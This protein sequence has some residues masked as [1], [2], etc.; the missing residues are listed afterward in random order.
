MAFLNFFEQILESIDDSMT[1]RVVPFVN[2]TEVYNEGWLIRLLVYQS[3]KYNVVIDGLIDFSE[4]NSW[5]S[6]GLISSPFIKVDVKREGYTHAD[7]ALGDFSINYG[8]RGEI[9]VNDDAKVFGIIEAKLKSNLSQKTTHAPDYNQASRNFAC[10]LKNANNKYCKT[11]F[12]VVA[13]QKRL[14]HYKIE[15]QINKDRMVKQ[16]I[17]RYKISNIP[18]DHDLISRAEQ[19][20]IKAFSY[21]DWIALLPIEVQETTNDFY[22]TC[23]KWNRL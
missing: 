4:I 7:M 21:E 18:V 19:A 22:R 1:S 3:K 12:A 20:I 17:E 8:E 11:F 5:T 9:I 13:P 14:D 23:L 10:V 2:P 15:A 6:E 16:I